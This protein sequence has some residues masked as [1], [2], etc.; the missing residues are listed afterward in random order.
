MRP[1]PAAT[2]PLVAL[3]VDYEAQAETHH[4]PHLREP[5][6]HSAHGGPGN[7]GEALGLK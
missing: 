3:A 4:R 2:C 5:Y 1:G 7:Y 6:L